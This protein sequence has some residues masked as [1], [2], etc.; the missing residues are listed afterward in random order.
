MKGEINELGLFAYSN[1]KL[2]IYLICPRKSALSNQQTKPMHMI[3]MRMHTQVNR[4]QNNHQTAVRGYPA[5]PV[6]HKRNAP[7]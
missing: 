1:N 3:L 6:R 2:I 7:N 5:N 4:G